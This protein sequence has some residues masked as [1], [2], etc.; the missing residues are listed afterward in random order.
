MTDPTPETVSAPQLGEKVRYTL[1]D[2]DCE[3][4]AR[5]VPR[6]ETR[7]DGSF[8]TRRNSVYPGQAYVAQVVATNGSTTVN[9]RVDLD[10]DCSWW[11]QSRQEG[12]GPGKWSRRDAG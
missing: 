5:D 4:I 3:L 10:G 2:Y 8:R 9:L 7:A 12:S 6:D 11:A 1:T